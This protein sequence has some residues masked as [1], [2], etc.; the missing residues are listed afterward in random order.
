MPRP[1]AAFRMQVGTPQ[2]RQAGAVRAA[3]EYAA[4]RW[5]RDVEAEARRLAPKN[6]GRLQAS[7][8]SGVLFSGDRIAAVVGADCPHAPF[9]E[10]GT[11]RIR[12]GTPQSPRTMWWT[13]W[14][15]GPRYPNPSATMP[16]LRTAKH[17][18]EKALREE[19]N[20]AGKSYT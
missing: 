20:K 1:F 6:T 3:V 8:Y 18:L 11:F 4:R 17:R 19:L 9:V 10:F 13:K 15:K 2:S 14:K 7:I 5:A 12:V 16:Y